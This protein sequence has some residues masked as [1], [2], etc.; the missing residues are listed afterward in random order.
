MLIREILWRKK[1]TMTSCSKIMTF[2]QSCEFNTFRNNPET[3]FQTHTSLLTSTPD[4]RL[5]LLIWKLAHT[6]AKSA[7]FYRAVVMSTHLRGPTTIKKGVYYANSSFP[8]KKCNTGKLYF[9]F[10]SKFLLLSKIFE[11][12]GKT[13][14]WVI[15]LWSFE[16]FLIL[17]NFFNLKSFS[18]LWGNSYIPCLLL[19]ITLRFTCGE[20][21][22]W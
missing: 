3:K 7:I 11:I 9:L 12:R 18:K 13:G 8:V 21:K 17:P 1:T 16:I 20:K 14:H 5:I 2:H 6:L 19:M 4:T 10:F 15:I 22:I